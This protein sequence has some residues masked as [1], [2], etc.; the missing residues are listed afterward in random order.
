MIDVFD[1]TITLRVANEE[2]TFDIKK[3]MKH[4]AD[5]DD[6]LYFIDTIMSHVGQCLNKMCGDDHSD[7]DILEGENQENEMHISAI[8]QDPSLLAS[9]PPSAPEVFEV[10][11]REEEAEKP[12]VEVPP[13]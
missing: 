9:N 11:V 2:D 5:Q 6:T 1:G 13:S 3:S 7:T 10:I 8:E 4:T 12:S